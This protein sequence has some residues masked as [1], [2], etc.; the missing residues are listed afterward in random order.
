M[1]SE[2]KKSFLICQVI[3]L[4]YPYS[5]A[6][7]R[8][9]LYKIFQNVA[10]EVLLVDG[11]KSEKVRLPNHEFEHTGETTPRGKPRPTGETLYPSVSPNEL[12]IQGM[13]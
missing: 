1:R 8:L 12:W 5:S 11:D 9:F 2:N 6:F 4:K 13:H 7:I 3:Y 10:A